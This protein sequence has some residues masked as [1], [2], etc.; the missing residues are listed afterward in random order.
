MI[1]YP[2]NWE[3]IGKPIMKEE[4]EERILEV[5]RNTCCN[6]L[7]LSGGLDSSLMLYFMLQVYE[8]VEVFTIGSS[9][10]HP[11][12]KYARLV[13][14]HFGV[15]EVKHRVYIPSEREIRDEHSFG[16]DMK[17]DKATRLFYRFVWRYKDRIISCDGAD[18]FNAGYYGHQAEEIER[19]Y[20]EYIRRLQ[21]EQLEPL[22]KNSSQVKVYLPYLDKG[23]LHLLCQIPVADKVNKTER[24]IFLVEM[25][26]GRIPDSIINRRK[27]G[28]CSALEEIDEVQT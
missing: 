20:Y 15:G 10:E 13:A 27:I 17:G 11:D 19:P 1:V 21:K 22:N 26:R 24:K 5:V 8:E 9:D 12:V 23:L 4:V 25:A 3:Q 18:E 28:F 16:S 14:E 6:S 7:A 2:R